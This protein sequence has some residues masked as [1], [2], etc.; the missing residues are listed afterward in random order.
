MRDGEV[1]RENMHN[2]TGREPGFKLEKLRHL[3]G[4]Q[5]KRILQRRQ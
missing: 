5:R 2:E 4:R 1:I 3:K